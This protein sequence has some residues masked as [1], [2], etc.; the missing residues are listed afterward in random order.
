MARPTLPRPRIRRGRRSAGGEVL[1]RVEPR[2]AELSAERPHLDSRRP[3]DLRGGGRARRA[4]RLPRARRRGRPLEAPAAEDRRVPGLPLRRPPLPVL[5]QGRPAAERG[6]ARRLHRAGLPD[7]APERRAAPG[8]VPLPPL[9][10]GRGAARRSSS[11]RDPATCSTT[12]ST[13]SSTTASRSSTRSR[14]SSTGSRTR[15][16]RARSDGGRPRHLEREAGDHRLPEDHQARARDAPRARALHAAL[17][18][19]GA[20]ALLR[21]PRGRGRADLGPPRQLQGGRRGARVDER[22]GHLP[23]PEHVLRMLTIISVTCS[24]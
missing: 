21:R 13:T 4:L 11:R 22:V 6:R 8:H 5:R 17:P 3:A 10:G 20:R 18:A 19:R 23:P 7:H 15:C 2:I 14:T 1:A 12:S 16:T 24:R 9:R